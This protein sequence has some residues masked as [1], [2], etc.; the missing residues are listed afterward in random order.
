MTKV[1]LTHRPTRDPKDEQPSRTEL[2]T[3]TAALMQ[4]CELSKGRGFKVG[5]EIRQDDRPLRPKRPIKGRGSNMH[6]HEC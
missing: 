3:V 4:T 6:T 5:V 1:R 2:D